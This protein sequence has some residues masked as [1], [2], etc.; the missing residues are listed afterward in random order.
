MTLP[1]FALGLIFS[2]L[3][4]SLFHVWRDGGPGRLLYYLGLSVAGFFAGQWIGTWRNWMVFE[5]G[6]L[7]LGVATVGS[8]LFLGLGYWLGL[9]EIRRSEGHDHKV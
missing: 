4:G 3:I 7:N 9:V 5:L 2:L 1:S 6:S 8:L